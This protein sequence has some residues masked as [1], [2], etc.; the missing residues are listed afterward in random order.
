MAVCPRCG[1]RLWMAECYLPGRLF[2]IYCGECKDD[3]ISEIPLELDKRLR[4]AMVK[5]G[6]RVL[7][8]IDTRELCPACDG[9]G[10]TGDGDEP[11]PNCSGFGKEVMPDDG[12]AA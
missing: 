4:K 8:N 9:S 1:G 7:D 5:A 3:V 10:L 2:A 11:C 12:R 6:Q